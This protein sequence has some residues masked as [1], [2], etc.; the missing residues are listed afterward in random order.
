MANLLGVG[1]ASDVQV[2]TESKVVTMP[3]GTYYVGDLCNVLSERGQ[4]DLCAACFPLAPDNT[5]VMVEGKTILSDG[6]TV[7]SYKCPGGDGEYQDEDGFFYSVDSGWFGITLLDG[8]DEEWTHPHVGSKETMIDLI[9]SVGGIVHYDSAFNV[10]KTTDGRAAHMSFGYK[11]LIC[12]DQGLDD[13]YSD[14]EGSFD[15]G[16]ELLDEETRMEETESEESL[17]EDF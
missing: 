6:R 5:N 2:M 1:E 3:P 17:D 11:V 13:L 15:E 10:K 8:L 9:E 14:E 12:T 7:V 16:E 4:S